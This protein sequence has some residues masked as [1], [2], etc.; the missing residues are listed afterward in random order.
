MSLK[1]RARIAES[2]EALHSL[3]GTGT[4]SLAQLPSLRPLPVTE[5]GFYQMTAAEYHADPCPEPSLSSSM[6]CAL[7]GTT[8]AHARLK[9]PR[10]NQA[11][12][13]ETAEHFDVGTIVHAAFLEGRDVVEVLDYN[14][15]RT[16]AAKDARDSA[17]KAGKVPLLRKVWSDVDRMLAAT[18]R[19]LDDHEDGIAMFTEG[20]A[21]PVLVWQEDGIWCRA[22]FDW[23]R[24]D[25][26]MFAIDDFKTTSTS[27]DPETLSDRKAWDMG[28]DIQ[29]SF[30]RRGLH[31]LTGRTAGFRFAVQ[32]IY[33]PYALSVLTPG[34]S[35][36]MLGDMRV[37]KA[38]SQ[39]RGGVIDNDWHAYP[40]RTAHFEV[41]MWLDKKWADREVRDAI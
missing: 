41:P 37:N 4:R 16:N 5:P 24:V 34:P 35:A 17:R 27:A 38:I 33:E 26:R 1:D 19:Q 7:M 3:F 39:W 11:M 31:T 9:H 22:R 23:L 13:A 40:R 29:A 30:Y 32:E 6:C 15:F 14:D 25:G 8:P 20:L 12:V 21:E 28:W 36:E 10:L 2:R 18:R